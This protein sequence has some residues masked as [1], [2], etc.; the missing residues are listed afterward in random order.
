MNFE[1]SAQVWKRAKIST[2]MK[3]PP[4]GAE[5]YAELWTD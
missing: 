5:F 1:L 2:L 3:T 4:T